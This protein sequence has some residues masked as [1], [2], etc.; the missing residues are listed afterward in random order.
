MWAYYIIVAPTTFKLLR[1][2]GADVWSIGMIP[3]YTLFMGLIAA[4]ILLVLNAKNIK[5]LE[6]GTGGNPINSIFYLSSV[7]LITIITFIGESALIVQTA[8]YIPFKH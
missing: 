5:R 2:L 4:I 6:A 1:D 7:Y 3:K 8:V